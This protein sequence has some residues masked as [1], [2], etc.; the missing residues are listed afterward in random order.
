MAIPAPRHQIILAA[1][2]LAGAGSASAVPSDLGAVVEKARATFNVPGMAVAVIKDGKVVFEQGFGQRAVNDT[3]KVDAQTMFCIASNTKSVTATAMA[4]LADEGKLHMD[5]RVV[6]HLPWFAMAEPYA[7]REIRLRDIL[8]HRSGLGSHAGDLLFLP[9]TSYSTR[10]VVEHLRYLPL[11]SGFRDSFAYENIMYAVAT[12]VVEQ[13]SGQSYGDFIRERIFKPLGMTQSRVDATELKPGDN[14]VMG[15]FPEADGSLMPVAPLAWKNNPGAAGIYS[16]VHDMALWARMQLAE[17]RLPAGSGPRRLFSAQAQQ[18][19]FTVVTPIDIDA[20]PVPALEAAQPNAFGYAE[21]WYVSDF[22]GHKLV[23]HTGG[24]PG[25]VSEVTLVPDRHLAIVVLTNQ[26]S[27]DAFNAITEHVIDDDL[28]VA[29]TDWVA[30]YAQRIPLH[31]AALRTKDQAIE[32]TRDT[33]V[34]PSLPLG[35][36]AGTY[37][38]PWYGD[39]ALTLDHGALH[40]NFTR[41]SRMTAS[42]SPWHGD[43][44]LLRLDDRQLHADALAT[45]KLDASHHVVGVALKRASARTASAYDYQDLDLKRMSP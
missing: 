19:M 34:K 44:F 36:Y 25:Q 11:S 41:S 23:W 7:T 24:F 15:N 16:S 10:E 27:E 37:R 45:F 18:Q 6:D 26:E 1:M 5:D 42:L 33:S 32:A 29:P 30:A 3:R 31:E 17:G 14:V 43:T 39:V 20:A 4:M 8:A 35:D 13:A 21:G 40:A 12:L 2:L 22:R 9:A 28:G 38:D